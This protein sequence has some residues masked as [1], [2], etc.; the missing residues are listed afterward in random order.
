MI[1]ALVFGALA[2]LGLALC[3]LGLTFVLVRGRVL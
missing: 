1:P 2:G 3:V